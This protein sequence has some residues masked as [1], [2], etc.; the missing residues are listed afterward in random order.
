MPKAE[1][2]RTA[3][4]TS[5]IVAALLSWHQD[6]DVAL[7]SLQELLAEEAPILLPTHVLIEAF[8]VM[9]RLPKPHRVD[10]EDAL[11]VLTMTLEDKVG[12]IGLPVRDYWDSL[13]T[14]VARGSRGG[15]V[16]DAEI[17]ECSLQAGATRILTLNLRHFQRLA[18]AGIE[19][20][21]P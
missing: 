8:S 7:A 20:S 10:P 1:V 3:I 6:H 9:T 18:P 19:V 5:V 21:R 17:I 11:T 4:D 13:R 2:T 15:A 12:L 16:Y 14:L